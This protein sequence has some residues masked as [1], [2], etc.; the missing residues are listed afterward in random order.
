[1]NELIDTSNQ[2][3]IVE[4]AQGNI[5]PA[6]P[7]ET[8]TT[9]ATTDAAPEEAK[10]T[11]HVTREELLAYRA[12]VIEPL[13]EEFTLPG[14]AAPVL[15]VGVTAY[16]KQRNIFAEIDRL[17]R[18]AESGKDV[19]TNPQTGARYKFTQTDIV[20]AAWCAAC[21][22]PTMT[23]VEWL[24]AGAEQDLMPLYTRCLVCSRRLE[25]TTEDADEED[26][27]KEDA[28]PEKEAPEALEQPEAESLQ[29][30]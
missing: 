2:T 1:M 20:A 24:Q 15:I 21:V 9:D 27:P 29:A 10:A 26:G 22:T 11:R 7:Q 25:E 12:P 5:S 18:I 6:I 4:D 13:S 16:A 19:I 14:F 28:A 23:A 3:D 17:A 8:A 30:G